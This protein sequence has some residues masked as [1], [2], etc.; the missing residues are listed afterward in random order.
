MF[1]KKDLGNDSI[2]K[3]VLSL[4]LPAMVAQFVNVLYSIVDRMFVGQIDGYG[5]LAL[6]AVGVCGPIV[7]LLSSFGTLVGIGGSIMMSIALGRK[8]HQEAKTILFQSFILLVGIS[9]LLTLV[10]L[11]L[12]R[13][14]IYWFGGSDALF[15]FANTYLTIY[16]LGT[17]FALLA[18][19]LNYFI[20][21]QGYSLVAMG[22]VMTGAICNIVL[23]AVFIKKMH[24]GIQGAA[25]ATVIAQAL[26]FLFVFSFL[27]SKHSQVRIQKSTV[28]FSLM[29][30]IVRLGFSPFV[31]TATD[32]LIIILM[33]RLLQV[34]G[35]PGY[36]DT[37]IS[38]VTIAQSAFLLITGPLLGITS[39]TQT[40]ISYNFGARQRKRIAQAFRTI[41]TMSIGFCLFMW[42]MA[43]MFSESFVLFFTQDATT[44]PL[45]DRAIHV[46]V[47]GVFFMA[48]QYAFVDGITALSNVKLSLMLSLTR[49]TLY[50]VALIV[51]PML[52]S[53]ESIF[54]AQ[55]VADTIACMIS[56]IALYK[57]WN[58]FLERHG[59]YK[60]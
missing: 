28:S 54:F 13:P 33:N 37:L 8:H 57:T 21:A 47:M 16:T 19:G 25:V 52:F 55:P 58:P 45:A 49:K 46:F 59:L 39:G 14:M 2:V 18:L 10:F 12:R 36:G 38:A 56:T 40:I 27:C 44:I 43:Q 60:V 7:T 35:G 32:S 3:L 41:T 22:S 9:L 6:A 48:I 20:T 31:I 30:Q 50:I 42:L 53:V 23:D 29:K 1:M 34:Y 4:A 17:C 11:A 15:D 5:N 51:L 26:S 24:M